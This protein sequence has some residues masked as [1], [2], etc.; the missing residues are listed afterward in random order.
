MLVADGHLANVPVEDIYSGVVS[1]QNLRL[2]VVLA[3]LNDL[4]L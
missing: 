4:E 3:E 2:V 1:L